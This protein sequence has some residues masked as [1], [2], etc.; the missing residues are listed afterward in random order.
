M[1]VLN[2]SSKNAKLLT[3]AWQEG[4]VE[5]ERDDIALLYLLHFPLLASLD[6]FK[7]YYYS[8]VS[9]KSFSLPGKIK[10]STTPTIAA[11]DMP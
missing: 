11:N 4:R 3:V 5:I 10:L 9:G 1:F 7:R 6:I 2:I 8:F